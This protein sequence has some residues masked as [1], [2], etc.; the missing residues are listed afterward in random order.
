MSLT[1]SLTKSV[2]SATY[3][4]EAEKALAAE[5]EK[6]NKVVAEI[7]GALDIYEKNFLDMSSKSFTPKWTL[8]TL[9]SNIKEA[10]KWLKDN[11][12]ESE[13]VY[14]AKKD[15]LAKKFSDTYATNALLYVSN[16]IEKIMKYMV[17]F[18][19]QK[20]LLN[21]ADRKTYSD[22]YEKLKANNQNANKNPKFAELKVFTDK[23]VQELEAFSK[24]RAIWDYQQT[25]L[26]TAY[27][28]PAKFEADF[29]TIEK[30]AEEAKKEEEKEFSPQRFVKKV[31]S[32]AGKVIGS[33]FYIMFCLTIGMMAANQAIGREPAYRVLYFIYG[34]IFAPILVFYYLYLWFKGQS[35]KIYTLLP[36]TTMKAETTLGRVFL[37]PFAFQEDK[38]ARDLLVDFM[39]KSAE[40]VGKTFDPK[41]LGSIGQQV[42][43]VAENLK[44]LTTDTTAA[45]K[46]LVQEL[47]KLNSLRVNSQ[48]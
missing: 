12:E 26:Q 21:A 37:F 11:P 1:S 43:T 32:T 44:N 18:L 40:M 29:G 17:G 2:R 47:P 19:E 20:K 9:D 31:S 35:P 30:Q 33:L 45:V 6:A 10:R 25:L 15:E 39:T 46:E 7:N 14:K 28:N 36:V 13:A 4:P 38:T 41:A 16:S 48:T 3:N 8:D 22:L 27:S 5:R 42:E 34:A 24:P 23:F